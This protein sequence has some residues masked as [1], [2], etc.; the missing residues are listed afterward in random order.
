MSSGGARGARRVSWRLL[1]D[2]VRRIA[3]GLHRIG[4]RKGDRVSLLVPPGPTLSAVVYA[5]LRIGAVVVVADAGLGIRGLT[6]AV[7]GAWPDF[8]IG[9]APGLAAARTLGWPGVRISAAQAP[10]PAAAALGV[11]SQPRRHRSRWAPTR[12]SRRRPGPTTTR[13]SSS[14]PAPP[15]PRRASLHARP[16]L[17]AARRARRPLRRDA[18]HRA[19][20]RASRRS[21]CS[22]R[23]SAPAR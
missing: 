12:R 8:I 3:A 22:G 4:V 9:E 18:R 13:R 20:R 14:P 16:A 17:R 21:R 11:V 19:R 2:R 6:R 23:R 10:A 15:A 1:D 5:C 7:R